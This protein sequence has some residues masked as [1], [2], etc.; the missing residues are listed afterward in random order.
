MKNRYKFLLGTV[1]AAPM[2]LTTSCIEETFPTNGVTQE[3]LQGSKKAMQAI[4]WGMPG[5]M[6]T[7]NIVSPRQDYDFGNPGLMHARDVMT[8][9]MVVE[10]AGGYDWFAGWSRVT[11]S[12][13]DLFTNCAFTWMYYYEQ[14]LACNACIGA[15]DAATTDAEERSYL[16]AGLAFRAATYLDMA[17]M[18]EFLPAL[19]KGTLTTSNGTNEI[20][21]LTCPIVTEATT[22]EAARNND[23]ATHAEMVAFIKKDLDE[24]I[25][26][27][28][29][30]SARM[31]KSLPDLAV[32]YGLMARLY[33][34]DATYTEEGLPHGSTESAATLYNEAARYARLAITTSGAKPM[35][36]DE[37]LSTTAGFNDLS[38]SSWMWG[39]QLVAEDA[40]VKNGIRNW[41]SFLSNE[42]D[43]GYAG[44]GAYVQIASGVYDRIND[45]DFRKLLFVAPKGS[46]LSGK[47]SYIDA[48]FA[49]KNFDQYYSLK[50]RPGSGNMIDNQVGCAV[51][52]PLMR[53][54]EMYLIEAEAKAHVN[55]ADGKDALV[56]FMKTF[57]YNTYSTN[58]TTV[59]DVVEEIIFQKRVELWGEGQTYY[60]VKRLNY[61]VV[62][63]YPGSNFDASSNAYNSTGRPAWMNIVIPRNETQNNEALSGKNN[64]SP[65]GAVGLGQM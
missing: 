30:A 44:A 16:G 40:C 7:Y 45:R 24:A 36:E 65:V 28:N 1:V 42:T 8:E 59:E 50:F 62:R 37:M 52:I 12:Q 55:A 47:E 31:S 39:Q 9:D 41:T 21:G 51:G 5:H 10:F 2:L 49:E 35:T 3:Q 54:E 26:L 6:N 33:L 46:K 25:K 20:V 29:G 38:V 48:A 63:A 13:D 61:S 19:Y 4:V 32:A 64:P 23:R 53:V 17:R 43:F 57:R 11:L 14:V 56:E 18:Y 58:A 60:D 34:W 27:F 22:E 15:I